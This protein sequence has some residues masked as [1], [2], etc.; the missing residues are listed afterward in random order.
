MEFHLVVPLVWQLGKD[1][2]FKAEVESK[3]F[4]GQERVKYEG[5]QIVCEYETTLCVL[6]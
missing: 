1:S 3:E 6:Q 2:V 5:E 4:G